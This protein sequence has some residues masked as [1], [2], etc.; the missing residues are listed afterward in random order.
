MEQLTD[1]QKIE[2]V[3]KALDPPESDY[4]WSRWFGGVL[5]PG[6]ERPYTKDELREIDD[7]RRKT[8]GN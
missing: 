3:E 4:W 8:R 6:V 7:R 5:L 2:S 1:E